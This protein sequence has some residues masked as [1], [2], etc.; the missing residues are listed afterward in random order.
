MG[1]WIYNSYVELG[2]M[3]SKLHLSNCIC[4]LS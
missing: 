4:V 1:Y 3:K 2:L